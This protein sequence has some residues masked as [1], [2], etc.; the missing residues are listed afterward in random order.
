MVIN[1][2]FCMWNL[3]YIILFVREFDLLISVCVRSSPSARR[4]DMEHLRNKEPSSSVNGVSSSKPKPVC[5]LLSIHIY[6]QFC[7]IGSIAIAAVNLSKDHVSFRSSTVYRVS[8][9]VFVRPFKLGLNS[10]LYSI[11][12]FEFVVWIENKENHKQRDRSVNRQF[13]K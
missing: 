7:T 12:G 10:R 9:Y 2:T 4:R 13:S 5:F 11:T 8:Y 1:S 3:S 6:A